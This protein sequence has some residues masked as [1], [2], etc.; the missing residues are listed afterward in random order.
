MPPSPRAS[1]RKKPTKQA[2]PPRSKGN[3]YIIVI[4]DS[5]RFDTMVAAKPKTIGKLGEIEKRWSYASWTAPSHYNLLSGL[6]P[7][8]NPQNVFASEYYKQDFLKYSQRLGIDGIGFKS[9]IPRL[10]FPTFLKENLGY[11][12]HAMVSLPVL[13][14]RTILN[15]GFDSFRLMDNHNDMRAMVREMHFGEDKPSFYLLNVGETH[16]PYALPDEPQEKW[17]RISGIHGVFKHLDDHIVGGKLVESPDKFFDNKKMKALRDR[18]V[19]AVKYLDRVVE[20]LFDIVPKNTYL[21]ITA[22]HGELFGES[23]FFGHGP[24]MHKKV[25]EVPFV[26]GKLR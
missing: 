22:D 5:C 18:Q 13:N 7:H 11:R 19:K 12:T 24:I 21:T 4:F 15:T 8:S 26:E 14:P 9:L 23:G 3:N 1:A 10:Y 20:E 6:L 25:F 2:E 17:P 16:Y